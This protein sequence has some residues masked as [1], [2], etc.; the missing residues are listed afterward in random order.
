VW[1]LFLRL[2][3]LPGCP[4]LTAIRVHR[5]YLQFD[6][7][8]AEDLIAYLVSAGMFREAAEHLD[9]VINDEGFR[10]VK[11]TS[12]RQLLL[13]LCDLLAQHPEDVA[14]LPVEAILRSAV[15]KFPEEA[16]V[17]WTTLA[18]YFARK[19]LHD[20]A[21]DVFEEGTTT[22]A[23]VKDLRSMTKTG[24]MATRHAGWPTTTTPTWPWRGWNG[25]SIAG[26]SCSTVFS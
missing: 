22:A 7:S 8:H 24:K 13:H 11:G 1:P 17:L 12:K 10:S 2:A 14:G 9:A 19:G 20:K 26:R 16:G 5:R 3:S 4:A 21:R 15:R 6:P 18:G 25:C 23:A